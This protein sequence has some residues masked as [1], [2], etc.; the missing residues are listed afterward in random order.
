MGYCDSFSPTS[1]S[2]QQQQASNDQ[3]GMPVLLDKA[4]PFLLLPGD[5][6]YPPLPTWSS[7]GDYRV[8]IS[9]CQWLI[10]TWGGPGL[11]G[12]GVQAHP[13][14][15]W[16]KIPSF[17]PSVIQLG[18]VEPGLLLHPRART[19]SFWPKTTATCLPARGLLPRILFPL[20]CQGILPSS[21]HNSSLNV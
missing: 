19:M 1:A 15:L 4:P 16:E 18:F 11:W 20:D 10:S 12:N 21:N 7:R 13:R 6:P 14:G 5:A 2:R 8:A 17:T 3:A 9:A